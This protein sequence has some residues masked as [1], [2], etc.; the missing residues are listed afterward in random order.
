MPTKKIEHKKPVTSKTWPKLAAG[1]VS[2]RINVP[3]SII[4]F[5]RKINI[6]GE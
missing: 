4:K 3:L 1:W 6:A 5:I 2:I